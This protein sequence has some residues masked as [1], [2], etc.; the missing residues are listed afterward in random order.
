VKSV[1]ESVTSTRAV[2]VTPNNNVDYKMACFLKVA[3]GGNTVYIG[4]PD[5]TTANG[6]PIVAGEV[7]SID[8]VNEPIYAITAST[9]TL[10][11]LRRGL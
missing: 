2:I 1:V 6:F 11:V 5:L 4:G 10:Y 7:A 8:V 9:A 3:T